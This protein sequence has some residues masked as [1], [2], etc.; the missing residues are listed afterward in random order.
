MRP[1]R[2]GKWRSLALT[3]TLALPLTLTTAGCR[4]VFEVSVRLGSDCTSCDLSGKDLSGADLSRLDLRDSNLRDVNLQ[5]ANLQGTN[6]HRADL[7]GANLEGARLCNTIW[8]DGTV[9]HDSCPEDAD[10]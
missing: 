2:W 5:N 10:D 7:E 1:G 3:T 8:T 9:R 4:T 6:L